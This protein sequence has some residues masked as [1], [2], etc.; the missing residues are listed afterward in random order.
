[1]GKTPA[2]KRQRREEKKGK[3]EDERSTQT[4]ELES[5]NLTQN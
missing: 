2:A 4:N 3:R 5:E 1:M